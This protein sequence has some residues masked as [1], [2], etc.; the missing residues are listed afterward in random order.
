MK[1]NERVIR[2]GPFKGKKIEFAST[3]GIGLFRDIANVFML[4]IFDFEPG[5]YLITDESSLTDF[6]GVGDLKLNDMQRKIHALY[7]VDVSDV[8]DG[9][10]LQILGRIAATD[11]DEVRTLHP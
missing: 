4:R 10:L 11:S 3:E 1:D 2:S 7:G 6:V 8:E 9:N 5:D